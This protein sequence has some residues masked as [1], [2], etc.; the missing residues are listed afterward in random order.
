MAVAIGRVAD[1]PRRPRRGRR[2]R[3][4][5][6]GR[7]V[8]GRRRRPRARPTTRSPRTCSST[9]RSGPTTRRPT[10]STTSPAS[11]TAPP[12][13][14]NEDYAQRAPHRRRRHP[15]PR[16]RARPGPSS[17]STSWKR[18]RSAASAPPP[19]TAPTPGAVVNTHHQ[20]GRQPVHRPLRRLLDEERASSATTSSAEYVTAEPDARR[21]GRHQ[22]AARPHR[23][24][25]RADHQGQAVLLRRRPA[26]RAAPTTRAGPSSDAHRGEPALQQ[27]A[28]LAARAQRQPVP[29]LP[30]GLLQ[31]DGPLRRRR[32]ACAAS[33]RPDREPGLARGD[34]GRCSGGTSSAPRPSARSSTAAGGATTTSTRRCPA[35]ISF[36]GTT[37]GR[38]RAAPATT[39]TPT[40]TRNQV[41]ASISHYAEAF[42]KHDLKF[43]VEIERSKVREPVRLHGRHLLLRLHRVLPEGPVPRLRLRLRQ[44]GQER[45]R[46]ALR[47]GL[48]E[49]HRA[50]H[51]QRRRARGLRPRHE[52]RPRQD[53]LQQHQLGPAARLR[54]RPD[55]RRQ[56][57]AQGPLRPVLRGHLLRRTTS[58][59]MP[60]FTGLRH[61][62]LRPG[63]REVRPAGNCFTESRP[64]PEPVYEVDPDI[65]HPRVDEWTVGLRARARQGR[66][67]LGDRHLARGQERPGLGLPRRA[68]D[69][70]HRDRLDRRDDP[71][72]NGKQ[73]TVYRWANR[74]ASENDGLLT[75][76]DGFQYLDPSGARARHRPD[77]AQVQGPD[78]RP[79]QALHQP[80]AG[81]RL[82]RLLEVRG[83]PA[84]TTAPTP[85]GRSAF[86]ETPDAR[87]RQHLRPHQ[88]RPAARAEGVRHLA[89]PEG[90]GRP[91]RLLP[92]PERPALH[93]VPA[94][95]H[96][97]HQLP[98]SA[99][100]QPFLEPRGNRRLDS[101]SYLD[102]RVEKIFN[103]SGFGTTAV[104]V[105]A[106]VQNVF[107][108]GTVVDV[109]ARYPNISVAG[110]DDPIAFEG[111]TNVVQPRRFLL[112][113]R[114]S[115]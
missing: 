77:R 114:W 63:R 109:N 96:E 104:A 26:L 102:L 17:T 95:R 50:A 53:G 66:P 89:D 87:A 79:R 62:R 97:R 32:R 41:N 115:F 9:C 83:L 113:A 2:H 36:D 22:Q 85:T 80:L 94:V 69:P 86:F 38:T 34:L 7:R 8:A 81:A 23:P 101:E 5:R 49:A 48:L 92:L 31:R 13:A 42:G 19:S 14:A 111:P 105:Y 33:R 103:V 39:T 12:S 71:S 20:V 82:L 65:K 15:R 60:G 56:D 51:H 30:V 110:Y 61:L 29:E 45:A 91:Q 46:V 88:Q 25:R 1:D 93:A 28:D 43:G 55:R 58:G 100:R 90:R 52:R 73:L 44:R 3:E 98:A 10:C 67:P 72:L 37:Q 6:R 35:R 57:R 68:L 76:L 11:T 70:D 16:R 21:P 40:A 18:C 106:D 108:A 99:G 54:L 107:N 112:G 75:N 24:D 27:Q 47:P 4:R 84:T 64:L 59:A 74:A 78:V